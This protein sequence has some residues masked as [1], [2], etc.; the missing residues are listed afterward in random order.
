MFDETLAKGQ[1]AIHRLDPRFKIAAAI[2]LSVVAGVGGSWPGAVL[3][4]AAGAALVAVARLP[5]RHIAARLLAVNLFVFALALIL[6][7]SYPGESLGQ[8]GPLKMS[9]DGA[10]L[11]GIILTK[12]NAVVMVC[13]ALLSTSTPVAT[14]HALWHMRVPGKIIQILFFTIRYFNVI[15]RQWHRLTLA[16][17]ARAFRPGMNLH[18]WRSCGNLVGML[19]VG[20]FDRAE[21]IHKAMLCRG[22]KGRFY[23]LSHFAASRRDW[24]FAAAVAPVVILIGLMQW[25]KIIIP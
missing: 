3:A 22:F 16:M 4:L 19:L 12:V 25:T 20:S 23:V 17:R 24:C 13:L 21:R 2:A 5:I 15:H 1:T 18:T 6:L 9:R 8:V 10:L 14:A 11:A 7:F